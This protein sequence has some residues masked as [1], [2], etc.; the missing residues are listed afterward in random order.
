MFVLLLFLLLKTFNKRA[1]HAVDFSPI[2]LQITYTYISMHICCI[3][4]M[5]VFSVFPF[6]VQ[7]KKKTII[8]ILKKKPNNFAACTEHD[9]EYTFHYFEF[10]NLILFEFLFALC[11]PLFTYS[12]THTQTLALILIRTHT[13]SDMCML[14][15]KFYVNVICFHLEPENF[16]A[17]RCE[18]QLDSYPVYPFNCILFT[19]YSYLFILYL[20]YDVCAAKEHLNKHICWR[21]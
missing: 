13:Q 5:C 14:M 3:Y 1:F 10:F 2:K 16:F 19:C 20:Y 7:I 6:H 18:L 15:L 8:N 9:R 21:E 12:H 11:Y 17:L 4:I